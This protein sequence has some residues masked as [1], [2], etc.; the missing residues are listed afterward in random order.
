[1]SFKSEEVAKWAA[2]KYSHLSGN[3]EAAIDP[4]TIVTFAELILDVI[5]KIKECRGNTNDGLSLV[6]DP[7]LFHR[8]SLRRVVKSS[9]SPRD[10]RSQGDNIISALLDTGNDLE[11]ADIEDLYREV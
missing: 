9:L 8:M 7:G 4:A 1:M 11:L 6:N 5:A 10:F 2:A 3:K